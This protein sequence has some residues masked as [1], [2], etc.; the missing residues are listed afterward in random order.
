LMKTANFA[1]CLSEE[2]PLP[3]IELKNQGE[4]ED[5]RRALRNFTFNHL[6]KVILSVAQSRWQHS[7]Y[8]TR[9]KSEQT[10]RKGGETRCL[11]LSLRPTSDSRRLACQ[12]E[13][14]FS[15]AYFDQLSWR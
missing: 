9:T 15:H 7:N 8:C 12:D 14:G 4:N 6:G 1:Q 5:F 2:R 11:V 13:D 10:S 3:D